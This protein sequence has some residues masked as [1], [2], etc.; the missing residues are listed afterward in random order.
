MK[1]NIKYCF[2]HQQQRPLIYVT[3]YFVET[4]LSLFNTK[5]SCSYFYSFS[6]FIS[7]L[8]SSFPNRSINIELIIMYCKTIFP[9]T[10]IINLKINHAYLK[11]KSSRYWSVEKKS[12]YAFY[13][14][15]FKILNFC[16]REE[17]FLWKV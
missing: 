17:S 2:N 5:L 1:N 7:V 16:R 13:G 11:R 12:S 15:E 6:W 8:L 10:S 3:I 4:Q 14:N 9:Y